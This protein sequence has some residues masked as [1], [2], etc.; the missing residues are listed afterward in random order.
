MLAVALSAIKFPAEMV[1]PLG[2]I[3]VSPLRVALYRARLDVRE[4]S[5][6][7]AVVIELRRFLQHKGVLSEVG[8]IGFR[9]PADLRPSPESGILSSDPTEAGS[10]HSARP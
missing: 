8:P 6:L 7:R 9:P 3:Q 1:F 5:L 10:N 2:P 4:A